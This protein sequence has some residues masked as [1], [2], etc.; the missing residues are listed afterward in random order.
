MRTRRSALLTLLASATTSAL[1]AGAMAW[2][3][4][5]RSA[6]NPRQAYFTNAPFVDQ[7]GRT[8]KFYDDVIRDKVVVLNMM[9]TVCTSICPSNTANLLKVQKELGERVGRDIHMVSISLMPELDSP[10][11]LRSYMKQYDIG[12]GWTFL[13]GT[14]PNMEAVRRKI[15]FYDTDPGADADI[16]RHTGMISIGNDKIER[17][18]MMPALSDASQIARSIKEMA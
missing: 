2:D 6:K 5:E 14:R 11:A 16:F 15:G 17:W 18:C 10:G 1:S 3:L 13:T 8:V 9:Y 7:G 12:P 4:E